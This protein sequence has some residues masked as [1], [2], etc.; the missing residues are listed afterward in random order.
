MH[1]EAF[2]PS[3]QHKPTQQECHGQSDITAAA[4]QTPADR[5]D[6]DEL[7]PQQ[8]YFAFGS[9]LSYTQMRSRC[10]YN[11]EISGVPLAIGRLNGWRWIICER[12]YANVV[13]CGRDNDAVDGD[14][15]EDENAVYGV[16]Y[17]MTELDE[18]FLDGYEGVD[19]DAPDTSS[20][21][22]IDPE[23]RPAEQGSGCYNKWYLPVTVT[24][25]VDER[26]RDSYSGQQKLSVLVYVDEYRCGESLPKKEYI[27]RMNRG[28]REAASLGLSQRWVDKVVRRY[29]PE[30]GAQQLAN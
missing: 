12:G 22:S 23:I 20:D 1:E 15:V 27:S 13:R 16:I 21:S 30:Q 28:I 17:S 26:T 29:I 8:L 10:K 25:W 19:A 7:L 9:N 6:G 3:I 11:P 4:A 24:E 14:D 2:H 5:P 18:L